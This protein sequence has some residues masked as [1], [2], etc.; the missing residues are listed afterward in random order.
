MPYKFIVTGSGSLEFKEKISESLAG[1][2]RNF[3]LPTVS[4]HEWLA[5]ATQYKFGGCLAHVL[6]T[7]TTLEAT[8]LDAYLTYGG[9]PRVVTAET[10]MEK[11]LILQEIYQA[12]IERDIR[13]LLRR[14]C[15]FN[16]IF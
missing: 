10:E 3:F 8:L 16:C 5:Y 15:V 1:R 12:Y 7:D 13:D 2:K 6:E 4:I 11:N 14:E 9:Y